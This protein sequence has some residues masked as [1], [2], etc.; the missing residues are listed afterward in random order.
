MSHSIFKDVL[1]ALAD[2]TDGY[3]EKVKDG[4]IN[5][6]HFGLTANELS[7]LFKCGVNCGHL[8]PKGKGQKPDPNNEA[9]GNFR[10]IL[11]KLSTK[12]D[13]YRTEVRIGVV[14]LDAKLTEEQ[15]NVLREA[16]ELCGHL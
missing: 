15:I 11:G 13:V 12:N 6:H 1:R 10:D 5:L 3:R 2:D 7:V 8:D 16:G 14:N 4:K 9:Q